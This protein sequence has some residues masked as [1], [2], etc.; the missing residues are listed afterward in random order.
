VLSLQPRLEDGSPGQAL[1]EAASVH[2]IY[3]RE[4]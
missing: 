3:V 2:Y 1:L 4:P